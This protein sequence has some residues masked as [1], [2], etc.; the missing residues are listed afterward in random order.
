M[1]WKGEMMFFIIFLAVL[2]IGFVLITLF[3]EPFDGGM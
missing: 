3:S 1:G 2:A